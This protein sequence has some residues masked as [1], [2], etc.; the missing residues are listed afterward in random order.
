MPEV[1][2][3]GN[4]TEEMSEIFA[5]FCKFKRQAAAG[6]RIRVAVVSDPVAQLSE[7]IPSL[8]GDDYLIINADSKAI[9]PIIKGSHARLVTFGFN[10][11][12][13]VTASSVSDSLLQVCIQRGIRTLSGAIREPQEFS[14]PCPTPVNASVVLGAVTAGIVCDVVPGF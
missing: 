6:P 13:C 8:T 9:F 7:I 4:N 10:N 12:A 1:S 14:A 3:I 11:K 5:H 2:L